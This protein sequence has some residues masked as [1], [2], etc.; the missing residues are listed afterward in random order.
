MSDY[1]TKIPKE[2][3]SEL[4]FNKISKQSIAKENEEDLNKQL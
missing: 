4:E 3:M 1:K 2:Y